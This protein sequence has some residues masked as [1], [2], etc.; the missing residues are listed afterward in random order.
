M[1]TLARD[2][3]KYTQVPAPV[4]QWKAEGA[5]LIIIQAH[6]A[7]YGQ[8]RSLDLIRAVA[9]AGLPWDAYVYQ[10]LAFTDWLPGALETLDM[11]AAE[12]LVPRKGWLDVE[13]VDSG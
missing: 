4:D 10:Y 13:D 11:A 6:P 1:T 8:S 5:Q 12:G 7:D 2:A 9:A 3:S